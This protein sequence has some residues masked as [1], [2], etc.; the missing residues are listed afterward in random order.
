MFL[1]ELNEKEKEVFW[2]IANLLID[3]DG[4]ISKF[5]TD[6]L[7]EYKKELRMDSL[8]VGIEVKKNIDEILDDLK[9]MSERRKKIVFFELLGLAYADKEYVD[10]EKEL[11]S[12]VKKKFDI[13]DNEEKIMQQSVESI[14]NIYVDLERIFN[15]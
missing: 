7:E 14:M 8:V 6:M 2:E 13:K 4:N 1:A 12:V 15:V 10:K 3:I 11:I 5:E 9:N